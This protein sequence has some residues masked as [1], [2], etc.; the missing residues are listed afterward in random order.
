MK[1]KSE[2]TSEFQGMLPAKPVI[3]LSGICKDYVLGETPG[4]RL[5]AVMG[6]AAKSKRG[7]HHALADVS[8]EVS[9]GE[10]VGLIGSNGA[11]KS[12]LLQVVT[13]TLKPT[14]GT[15]NTRGRI[16][17]LLE[18]G[19]GFNPEWSGR[20]NA[21]FQ[22]IIQG[23]PSSEIKKMLQGI[24]Q[25]ADI[26]AYFDEPARTYS[27]GMFLRVA[28][29]AAVATDPDILIVDEALAVGDVRFQNK[30]YARFLELQKA[31]A[32]I[33][34]VTHSLELIKRFC[35]RGIVL[36]R[37]RI[38]FDGNPGECV[39]HYLNLL[40]GPGSGEA[41][42]VLSAETPREL[43]AA[44][45]DIPKHGE[46]VKRAHYNPL[47]RRTGKGFAEILDFQLCDD[48]GQDLPAEIASGRE[49]RLRIWAQAK[50]DITHPFFGWIVKATNETHI[51]GSNTKM[52]QIEVQPMP[53]GETAFFEIPFRLSLASGSYFFDLGV[54]EIEDEDYV[55]GD[56]RISLASL[57]VSE[58]GSFFG[59]ASLAAIYQ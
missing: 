34:F 42:A 21:E 55:S 40:H 17:A 27:S 43:T 16:S 23:V 41:S 36:D 24:E 51:Y 13:G 56:W 44:L 50:R 8:L 22:C 7:L 48:L 28:F 45:P 20:R 57:Y 31:G 3:S 38:S 59:L 53:S 1:R 5:R 46:L 58:R 39:A 30:C 33:I 4:D 26:G 10:T 2:L 9:S 6:L 25:F 18:L 49:V 37:G 35:T 15:A 14:S 54:G 19:A 29:A 47:G 12:T 11:G 52:S 32:T